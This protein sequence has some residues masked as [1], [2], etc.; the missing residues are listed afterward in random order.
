M[1]DNP[2]DSFRLKHGQRLAT[3]REPE[4]QY[5]PNAVALT[6]GRARTHIGYVTMGQSWRIARQLDDGQKLVGM[7]LN[8]PHKHYPQAL[9]TTPDILRHL[10]RR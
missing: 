9:I 7:I 5:D 10:Q 4:N 1:Y 6:V 2:K 3:R 8:V